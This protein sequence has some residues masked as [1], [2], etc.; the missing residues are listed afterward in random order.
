M[1]VVAEEVLATRGEPAATQLEQLQPC[2]CTMW[3]AAPRWAVACLTLPCAVDV[4]VMISQSIFVD[5]A[6]EVGGG[7]IAASDASQVTVQ[8]CRFFNNSMSDVGS[9]QRAL[10]TRNGQP[11]CQEGGAVLVKDRASGVYSTH[12][13]A[14]AAVALRPA[15]GAP[16]LRAALHRCV[17][18][19]HKFM[20]LCA[21][22]K[23]RT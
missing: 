16:A 11:S 10:G 2:T 19:Q 22:Q 13:A 18:Q 15:L 23:I 7:A 3:R 17:Q 6:G 14:A 1:P 4:A 12:V 8:Q 5:N 21:P 20:K 9:F